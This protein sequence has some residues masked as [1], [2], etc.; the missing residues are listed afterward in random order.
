MNESEFASK[1]KAKYPEYAQLSDSELTQKVIAKYPEYKEHVQMGGP[2][3]PLGQR[4][5]NFAQETVP[6]V[7]GGLGAAAA[8]PLDAATGNPLP[9]IAAGG[10]G[11]G[12]ARSGLRGIGQRLGYEKSQTLGQNMGQTFA[13]DVPTG[14][15]ME[16]AP[17]AI[18]AVGREV[19]PYAAKVG[20]GVADVFGSATGV[21]PERI[22]NV[23]KNPR[24]MLP[25]WMGGPPPIKEAGMAQ[26][27]AEARLGV[28]SIE[29]K[30]IEMLYQQRPPKKV[31]IANPEREGINL[32]GDLEKRFPD[33]KIREQYVA[34]VGQMGGGPSGPLTDQ[35][36]A[37]KVHQKMNAG[38]MPTLSEAVQ[39]LRGVDKSLDRFPVSA[40]SLTKEQAE[41][42]L[43]LTRQRG[44]LQN[45]VSQ[46]DSD[47]AKSRSDY[48][49]AATRQD[50]ISPAGGLLPKTGADKVSGFYRTFGPYALLRATNHPALAAISSAAQS[51]LVT[52]LTSA[53][54]GAATQG[55][56]SEASRRGISVLADILR[57]RRQLE[58]SPPQ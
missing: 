39:A 16:A 46:S 11:F 55:I 31:S 45:F 12:A 19:A 49:G 51:P 38:K 44:K 52:G 27:A 50:F 8:A 54:L 42:K 21:D 40:A 15:M 56:S 26:G 14:A 43:L 18:G 9:S 20:R 17:R 24:T 6:Y 57:R 33:P 58:N 34:A 37:F 30:P 4:A 41:D 23:F 13:Q 28:P 36:V 48:R 35:E 7:A 53:G 22:V 32:G 3:M 47:L 25:P 2:P 29:D 10:L 1:V 5:Y